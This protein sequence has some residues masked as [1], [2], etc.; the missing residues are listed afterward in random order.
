MTQRQAPLIWREIHFSQPLDAL[1]ATSLLER[2]LADAHL[3]QIVV[4]TRARGGRARTLV[5]TRHST[6]LDALV[7]SLVP[8]ARVSA[9]RHSRYE[10]GQTLRLGVSRPQ[11]PGL[12]GVSRT[13]VD[14]VG[15]AALLLLT[16][17]CSASPCVR[18][19][20]AE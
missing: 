4:E 5:A 17:S 7:R 2:I 1:A 9:P 14:C 12:P 8:G 20:S 10:T 13:V 15:Q 11:L 19:P 6:G 16:K 18:Y 3:G